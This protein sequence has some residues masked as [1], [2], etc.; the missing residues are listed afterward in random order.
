MADDVAALEVVG[1][2]R[3]LLERARVVAQLA[4]LRSR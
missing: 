3:A 4:I 1:G 2:P